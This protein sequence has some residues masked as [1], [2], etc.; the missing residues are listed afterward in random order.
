MSSI[1]R[2]P[3]FRVVG[4]GRNP[5]ETALPGAPAPWKAS[6]GTEHRSSHRKGRRGGCRHSHGESGSRSRCILYEA[7][8]TS[9]RLFECES[10]RFRA[11]CRS[12]RRC[13][14]VAAG[15]RSVCPGSDVDFSRLGLKRRDRQLFQFG[16]HLADV[17][18]V[19]TAEQVRLCEAH[20]G[21]SPVLIR[22][23]A[24]VVP[25]PECDPEAFL[26]IG[27]ML[28]PSD[29]RRSSDWHGLFPTRRS[30]WWRCRQATGLPPGAHG[31]PERKRRDRSELAVAPSRPREE[32]MNLVD[33]AVAM[34]STSD[35]EGMP[36]TF[37]E[38]WARGVPALALAHDPDGSSSAMDWVASAKARK[39]GSPAL[40][41]DCGRTVNIETRSLKRAVDT[42]ST[43][44]RLKP[45]ARNGWTCRG[46]RDGIGGGVRRCVALH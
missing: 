26:W 1:F 29:P 15:E 46:F 30:G 42:S 5:G 16:L 13:D 14:R 21:R 18:V 41:H 38:G 45:S 44:I 31:G 7:P 12:R 19:Q 6:R 17:I 27:R 8:R 25:Q 33:R 22:S 34:V 32:L 10:F 23:L 36:N 3:R 28:P 35:F 2:P 9:F 40:P 37:L 43:I 20:T 39:S 4:R 24:E 11:R